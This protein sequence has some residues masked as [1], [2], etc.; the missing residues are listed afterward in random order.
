MVSEFVPGAIGHLLMEVDKRRGVLYLTPPTGKTIFRMCR[1]PTEVIEHI[2]S[3]AKET[4]LSYSEEGGEIDI[5]TEGG[6]VY[7]SISNVPKTIFDSIRSG[8]LADIT[9]GSHPVVLESGYYGG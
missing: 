9:V 2:P 4:V 1:I 3:R 6:M 8:D 7:L 5:T